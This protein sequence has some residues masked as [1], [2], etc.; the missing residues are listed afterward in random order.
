MKI[1]IKNISCKIV[2]KLMIDDEEDNT[3]IHTLTNRTFAVVTLFLVRLLLQVI[4][5]T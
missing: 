2:I 4:T 1:I 5:I 3:S